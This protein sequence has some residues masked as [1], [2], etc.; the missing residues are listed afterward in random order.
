MEDHAATNK[1]APRA[2]ATMT[3]DDIAIVIAASAFLVVQVLVVPAWRNRRS[4]HS[5]LADF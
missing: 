2:G 1:K 4:A 5:S 3:T